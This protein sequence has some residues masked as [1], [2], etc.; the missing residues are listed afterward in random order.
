M[1]MMKTAL[2]VLALA[3]SGWVAPAAHAQAAYP[4]KPVRIIVPSAPGGG[5][6]TVTRLLARMR[7]TGDEVTAA[8][9]GVRIAQELVR[10][11]RPMAQ[12]VHI[13]SPSGRTAAAVAVLDALN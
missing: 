8:A 4:N 11:L 5:T 10:E 12:G 3:A 7:A 1:T 13:S 2:L 9:E 6:D